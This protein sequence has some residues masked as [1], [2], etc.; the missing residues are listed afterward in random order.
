M[1]HFFFIDAFLFAGLRNQARFARVY[2]QHGFRLRC[3]EPDRNV[4]QLDT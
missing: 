2:F 4:A 1:I 3:F